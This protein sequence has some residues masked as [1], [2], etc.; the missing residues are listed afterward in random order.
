[1]DLITLVID[2]LISI[3]KTIYLLLPA[4]FANMAPVFNNNLFKKQKFYPMDFNAKLNGKPLF[5]EHKTWNGLIAAII[6][7][8]LVSLIQHLLSRYPFFWEFG[9]FSYNNWVL[10][11]LLMGFG[12][13]IGDLTKSF[14]KRRIGKKPGER[15]VPFDQLDF[16]I[17][18]LIFLS[19][20]YKIEAKIIIYALI[21]SIILHI[22]TNHIGF[23]LGMREAKW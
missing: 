18:A 22:T 11:G 17:G 13:I 7:A 20:F 12:A 14:F 19:F 5:G 6:I 2:A 15:W 3:G 1:M 16:I 8:I 23:Y 10:I 4:Y 9:F 21:I